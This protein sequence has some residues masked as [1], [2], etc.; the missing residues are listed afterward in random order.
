MELTQLLLSAQS[1]DANARVAA[2][3]QLQAAQEANYPALVEELCSELA[4]ED[5]PLQARRL[6]GIILKNSVDAKDPTTKQTLVERWKAAIDP[7][8]NARVRDKLLQTLGSSAR[9]ASHTAAQV[10]AK[11]AAIEMSGGNWPDLVGI[12]LNN[13]TD[14][15]S[16][17]KL[18]TSTLETMGYLCEEAYLGDLDVRVL[19]SHSNQILTA[20]VSGMKHQSHSE[21]AV[22]LVLAAVT[23]LLNAIEF[24]KQNFERVNERDYIMLSACEVTHH[25]DERIRKT[26]FECLVKIAE[27][28]YDKLEK[29]ITTLFEITVKAIQSDT[30][31]VAL[32]AIEFWSTIAEEEALILE[33]TR[34]ADE[35]GQSVD[36][37]LNRYAHAALP[38][39][40]PVIFGCLMQQDEDLD[41]DTWNKSTAAGSCLVLLAEVAPDTIVDHV[42][43]FVQSNI[44]DP[45][46]WRAR[47]AATMA[48]GSIL[49]GPPLELLKPLIDEAVPGLILFMTK[50]P[51][52]QVRDTAA[53]TLGKVCDISE[54]TTLQYAANLAAVF[55]QS[56]K[57]EPAV[58]RNTCWAIHNFASCFAVE[59]DNQSG[60]LSP[61]VQHLL[62]A[63]LEAT[64]R[65][66]AGECS[67]RA[68]AYEA[69]NAIFQ[70]CPRDCI[71]SVSLCIPILLERLEQTCQRQ[72]QSEEER[73]ELS[74]LQGLLC[75]ALQTA[76]QRLGRAVASYADRMMRCYFAVFNQA[77]QSRQASVHE[78]ALM[79]VGA[80]ADAIEKDFVEYMQH[81]IPYL[82]VGLRNWEQYQVCG[83]AVGVVGDICRAIDKEIIPY[84][85]KIVELLLVALASSEL[86][87]SIKPPIFSCFGDLAMAVGG[88]FEQYLPWV[89]NYLQQAAQRSV[90]IDVASDDY[91]MLDWV[92]SLRES[93]FEAY[94]GII[95]GLK[96]DN[97]QS[98]LL[99]FTPWMLQFCE[100]VSADE[101]AIQSGNDSASEKLLGAAVGVLLDL[102]SSLE[103]VRPQVSSS[104]WVMR[105]VSRASDA[106]DFSVR[107][108][109][110]WAH[111]AIF[112]SA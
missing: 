95:Q 8:V 23:A 35:T 41:E 11:L 98:L 48:F 104:P 100:V 97:K 31:S 106:R 45:N 88:H 73:E 3:Q 46:N 66:D 1:P 44:N 29:Y 54:T 62:N 92:L 107:E 108:T 27:N 50:D 47:E 63:L 16:S 13:A 10:I 39:L 40:C 76:N 74:E 105:L 19:S 84:A 32:Q 30:E 22:E 5:R 61:Y 110:K 26:A 96:S 78:E 70:N 17:E 71:P 82:E 91:D 109:A 12:L 111:Q 57:D 72:P 52:V 67:M 102:V 25:P 4:A 15:A 37:V 112:Q 90:N 85:S 83:V 94:T 60:G 53:W 89:M 33:D 59:S 68:S 55:I 64:V 101:S 99:S 20:V 6:A 42:L 77:T 79:A 2:E 7:A 65:E 43:P 21:D 51:S 28:Y 75:G 80:V 34:I 56:L 93:V 49:E 87:K 24:V 9:D 14:G 38:H 69:I 36:H 18:K 103:E 58:A 86:D 81:F